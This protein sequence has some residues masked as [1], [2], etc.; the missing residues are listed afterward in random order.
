[1]FAEV[2]LSKATPRL[3]K[4]YHYE[5]PEELKD[6]AQIGAQVEIP[7]GRRMA[8]GYIVGIVAESSVKGI[9]KIKA[10]TSTAPFFSEKQVELAKW[11][12]E[13]YCS[14]FISALRLVMPP[15]G[16]RRA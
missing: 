15:G 3:D 7:F 8:V 12:S 5:I 16:K 14:F 4:I 2:I 11:I 1:M 6:V 10:V 9:K 13:Y